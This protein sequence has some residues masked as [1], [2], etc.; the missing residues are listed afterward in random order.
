[1]GV[2]HPHSNSTR[3]IN[4]YNLVTRMVRR[5]AWTHEF[6]SQDV[7][8]AVQH[9]YLQLAEHGEPEGDVRLYLFG[10]ARNY[11]RSTLPKY[12]K[13]TGYWKLHGKALAY[14]PR[15]VKARREAKW[16]E[17]DHSVQ[18]SELKED[19]QF[20][21]GERGS[22]CKPR[23][24]PYLISIPR[25]TPRPNTKR[26]QIVFDLLIDRPPQLTNKV[27]PLVNAALKS[28]KL[29]TN[30]KWTEFPFLDCQL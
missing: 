17:P 4:V 9:A 13:R 25:G 29:S 23:R 15:T 8:D 12:P 27:R 16:V 11:L 26:G 24:A 3:S 2:N 21:P 6:T 7:E 22:I 18:F 19:C 10:I 14:R 28:S 5:W 20:E 30:Y 1:V